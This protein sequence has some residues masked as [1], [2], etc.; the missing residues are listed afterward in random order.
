MTSEPPK[1]IKANL[2]GSVLEFKDEFFAKCKKREEFKIM[3]SLC[4]F[5]AIVYERKK[6]G[7]LGWNI[8]YYFNKS[9]LESSMTIVRNLLSDE[10]KEEIPWD[11]LLYLVGDIFY[12]GRVTDGNDRRCLNTILES[13]LNP[14]I[15]EDGYSY[16]SSGI[17]KLPQDGS[18]IDNIIEYV[19]NLPDVDPP[20][21][22]GMNENANISVLADE[23]STLIQT[24]LSIQSKTSIGSASALDNDK[25]VDNIADKIN[26]ELP[27]ILT[28]EGSSKELFKLNKQGLLPSLTIY[29]QQ[30]MERFNKLI[31]VIAKT[32][33]ELR[34]AIIGLAVMSDELDK[35]YNSILMNKVPDKW[36]E[37]AYPSLKPLGSWVKNLIERVEFIRSWLV[38][39]KIHK[40]WMPCFF[41]PARL[42][43]F[44]STRA[45]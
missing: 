15:L 25:F 20:E 31:E 38:N 44:S 19:K 14:A 28:K 30:E 23:S 34:A 37:N 8:I 9:D 24:V 6:F 12:G 42:L 17:Y 43:Y 10:T 2:Y 5:H 16:T 27:A 36:E 13:F 26:Q 11:A 41:F 29:L 45:F 39:G 32:I 4:W 3:F 21:I 35:M 40:F 33:E 1:G 22:F 7:S 18:D